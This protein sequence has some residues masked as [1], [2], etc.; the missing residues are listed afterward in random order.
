MAVAGTRGETSGEVT[1]NLKTESLSAWALRRALRQ[2]HM[3][4][5]AQLGIQPRLH[6]I[7]SLSLLPPRCVPRLSHVLLH[8]LLPQFAKLLFPVIMFTRVMPIMSIPRLIQALQHR[9]RLMLLVVILLLMRFVFIASCLK[10]DCAG[11]VLVGDFAPCS[12]HVA[13][14]PAV[15][16]MT[17][18][19]PRK[20]LY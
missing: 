12:G 11:L 20:L 3:P 2:P 6:L 19:H 9:L 18:T 16:A 10:G 4:A 15:L 5:A 13:K 14:L 7:T 17:A 8:T 1:I